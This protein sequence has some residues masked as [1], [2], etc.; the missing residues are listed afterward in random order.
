MKAQ[1]LNKFVDQN[2]SFAL[3]KHSYKNFL[4]IWHYHPEL[5]LVMILESNGTRFVGDNIEKFKAGEIVLIGKNLPHLWLND[6]AYFEEESQLN[7]QA[8]VIRF[9]ESFAG[10]LFRMPEMAAIYDLLQR[11]RLG[12]KFT[13]EDHNAALIQKAANMFNLP[14]FEKV[15]ALLELLK[16]LADQKAYKILSSNG[17]INSFKEI[18]DSK[19]VRIYEHI[20]NHFKEDISLNSVA[21]LANMNPSAFSRYF[22][23]IH[24]KPFNRYLNEVRIGYACKLL[25]EDKLSIAAV[26]YEAGFNNLSNFNRQFRAIKDM[27][28]SAYIKLHAKT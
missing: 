24:K 10:D 19:I 22:K 15:M 6:E 8:Y 1:L 9:H 27:S 13:A 12:I 2:S 14:A 18:H 26:C 3:E 7:A 20:M 28:P 17:Y 4:K 25:I 11:A 23:N 5:E 16:C 21:E